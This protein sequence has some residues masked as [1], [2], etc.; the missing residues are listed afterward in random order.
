MPLG[1]APAGPSQRSRCVPCGLRFAY[2]ARRAEEVRGGCLTRPP[3]GL[4][5]DLLRLPLGTSVTAGFVAN[6]LRRPCEGPPT[7]PCVASVRRAAATAAGR[8]TYHVRLCT[9]GARTCVREVDPCGATCV[10]GVS[11]GLGEL[12]CYNVWR[13][14]RVVIVQASPDLVHG[15]LSLLC[16]CLGPMPLVALTFF[17]SVLMARMGSSPVAPFRAGRCFCVLRRHWLPALHHELCGP[18]TAFCG[19]LSPCPAVQ[20]NAELKGL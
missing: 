7:V 9:C 13:C 3:L 18:V 14:L 12:D 15:R 17:E 4:S 2:D 1:T 8:R 11:D 16:A 10:Q 5:Y 6:C 19:W 20:Y